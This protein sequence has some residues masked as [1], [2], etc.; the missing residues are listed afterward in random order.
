MAS[1]SDPRRG[2]PWPKSFQEI[3]SSTQGA[4]EISPA[5]LQSPE[6]QSLDPSTHMT[7]QGSPIYSPS[8]KTLRMIGEDSQ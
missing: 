2:G 7:S 3:I 8:S 5:A 6:D 1:H 4:G